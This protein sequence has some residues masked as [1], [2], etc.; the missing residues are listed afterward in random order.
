MTEPAGS[1]S[2][3]GEQQRNSTAPS[4]QPPIVSL[5]PRMLIV[6][7]MTSSVPNQSP[8]VA[9]VTFTI[10]EDQG[11]FNFTLTY[12]DPERD[13]VTFWLPQQPAH[14][15]AS[16]SSDTKMT[17]VPD[18]NYTGRD[19]IY[20]KGEC[21]VFTEYESVLSHLHATSGH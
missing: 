10:L 14:G 20:V 2:P 16:I 6:A 12:T 9:N 21:K 17:Y 3:L 4:S 19:L 8:V 15:T 5:G 7:V 13:H 1:G 18:P 11:I